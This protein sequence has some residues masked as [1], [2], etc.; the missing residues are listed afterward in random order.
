[1]KLTPELLKKI[2][3]EELGK[4]GKERETEK[5]AKDTEEVDADGFA[6][7]L[8]KQVDMMKVLKIEEAKI[9]AR[10]KKIQEKKAILAKLIVK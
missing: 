1:M 3:K 6:D 8:E 5:V 10:L 2:V 9:T 4:F 7:T